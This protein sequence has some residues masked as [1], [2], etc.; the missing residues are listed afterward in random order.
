MENE[1]DRFA[2]EFLMPAKE[3]GPQL[4]RMSL[5]RAAQLK[6]NWK[7]SMASLIYRAQSSSA[8]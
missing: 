4:A 2:A 5:R 1:A 7:V 6:P 3:I 8:S